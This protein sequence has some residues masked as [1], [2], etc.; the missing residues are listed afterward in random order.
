MGKK[1]MQ[2]YAK[3]TILMKICNGVKKDGINDILKKLL[4]F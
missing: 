1:I 4:R 2:A 3:G